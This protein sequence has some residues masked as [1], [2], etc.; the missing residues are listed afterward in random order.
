M[1]NF[2]RHL[3]PRCVCFSTTFHNTIKAFEDHAMDPASAIVVASG[4]I[5]FAEF[6]YRFLGTLRA[7]YDAGRTLEYDEL[8]LVSNRMRDLSLDMLRELPTSNQSQSDIALAN[9]AT[10]CHILAGDIVNRIGKNKAASRKIG[11]LIKATL[12][13]ICSKDEI[14]R[15]QKNLETCRAQIHLHFAVSR[16]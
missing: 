14:T 5:T 6:T 2:S 12:R 8:E 7:I 11:D 13:T 1:R 10:Q 16:R 15:L 3:G 9:L 4:A